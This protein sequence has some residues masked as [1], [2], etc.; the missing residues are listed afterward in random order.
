[1][2]GPIPARSD[3]LSRERDANRGDRTPIRTGEMLPVT[4]PHADPDWHPIARKVWESLKSSG[5]RSFYQNSDWA[6]AYSLMDDL[7]HYKKSE[8]RSSMQL[9]A[10][11]QSLTALGLT[12][13]DRRRMRVELALPE[14]EQESPAATAVANYKGRL[15][16]IQGGK[17][18]SA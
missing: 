12:E 10:I 8:K 6:I 16:V 14:S 5:M 13:G 17:K 1:M 18:E 7:S 4:V 3:E 9:A 11:M 2:P 15:G